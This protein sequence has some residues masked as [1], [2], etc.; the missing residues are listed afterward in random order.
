MK[1]PF[2]KKWF[3]RTVQSVVVLTTLL[4]LVTAC[5][6]RWAA[7]E[8]NQAVRGME[9]SGN[10]VEAV[11][12]ETTPPPDS[13]NF[14]MIPLMVQLREQEKASTDIP[15]VGIGAD[16]H[17]MG[18]DAKGNTVKFPRDGTEVDLAEWAG[19][20]ALTGTAGRMLEQ[21]DERH[22]VVLAG[23]REGLGRSNAA[24]P[25]RF[26]PTNPR[27]AFTAPCGYLLRFRNA[28]IGLEVRADLAL[29][30]GKGEVA[31][32]SAL[33]ARSLS[34]LAASE[35]ILVGKLVAW[36]I[37]HS[38]IRTV[39]RG[40]DR[41]GWDL[42][43]I[44][45]IRE[46]WSRRNP[47]ESIARMLNVEGMA[48]ATLY[49]HSKRDRGLIMELSSSPR[50]ISSRIKW[51][52][53]PDAWF[54]ANAAGILDRTTEWIELI[55]SDQ[56]LQSWW[57]AVEARERLPRTTWDD[58]LTGWRGDS[59]DIVAES[60]LRMGSRA[61]VDDVLVR[62][63]CQ[64]AEHRLARGSYPTSLDEIGGDDTID[65]L[66][67]EPFV[68]RR[69]GESFALYSIGPDGVDDGGVTSGS[70]QGSYR[71]QPDWVWREAW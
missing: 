47:E 31:L 22:R 40:L 15:G 8:K 23:L 3:R 16:L 32:E 69:E 61:I 28:A 10:L 39:K 51:E 62:L 71:F 42:A 57:D 18:V 26:D 37:D 24:M 70:E 50:D 44:Q 14:A 12:F 58:L 25:S 65:P 17:A 33:M 48:M 35:D 2:R 45:T 59:D 68:Y 64:L 56:P 9:S 36:N 67:G 43:Q 60:V 55:K 7:G 46:A 1:N 38:L 6:N 49:D 13:E 27:E 52:L 41:E 5:L 54:D 53:I 63:A 11:A 29:A 20:L 4:V 19:S 21:F 66:T 30:A 34:D